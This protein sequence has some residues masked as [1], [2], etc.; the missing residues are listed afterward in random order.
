MSS[1]I[2]TRPRLYGCASGVVVPAIIEYS[3]SPAAAE[4]EAA[5]E[6]VLAAVEPAAEPVDELP[7]PANTAVVIAA[8]INTD[9]I[10]FFIN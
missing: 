7:H 4:P 8:T 6:P 5:A 10:L 2:L 3:A 1:P 9:K